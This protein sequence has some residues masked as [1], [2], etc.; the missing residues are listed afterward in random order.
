MTS[1]RSDTE[2]DLHTLARAALTAAPIPWKEV[3][4]GTTQPHTIAQP[5]MAGFPQ[6]DQSVYATNNQLATLATLAGP[7]RSLLS[8]QVAPSL[9]RGYF[10]DNARILP[11]SS[12]AFSR[13]NQAPFTV[14]G[15]Y[16]PG[17]G[18]PLNLPLGVPPSP[19]PP[20]ANKLSTLSHVASRYLTGNDASDDDLVQ[21]V[22]TQERPTTLVDP[23]FSVSRVS[24]PRPC[25]RGPASEKKQ[26]RHHG[27]KQAMD[28]DR[29][30]SLEEALSKID[31]CDPAERSNMLPYR[32]ADGKWRMVRSKC[33]GGAWVVQVPGAVQP[34]IYVPL[35]RDSQQGTLDNWLKERLVSSPQRPG[36]KPHHAQRPQIN[37][38]TLQQQRCVADS[39]IKRM[40]TSGRIAGSIPVENGAIKSLLLK[41]TAV[42]S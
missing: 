2:N 25:T 23:D 33:V 34:S 4:N 13:P 20:Q 26:Q 8:G 36:T 5:W 14:P 35:Q 12:S 15:S 42:R 16:P 28:D 7:M 10:P 6:I 24:A 39:P 22:K 19:D 38:L 41:N 11:L 18:L 1:C 32:C 17:P 21:D 31:C 9:L 30:R 29:V 3:S 37:P 40:T 27:G